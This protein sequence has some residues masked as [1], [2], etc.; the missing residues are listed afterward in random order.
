MLYASMIK[1]RNL[2]HIT[3]ILGMLLCENN[4]RDL[5]GLGVPSRKPAGHE[6]WDGDGGDWA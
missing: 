2:A 6:R 3:R 5:T 4:S 1:T